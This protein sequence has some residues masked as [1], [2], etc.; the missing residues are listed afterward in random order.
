MEEKF[1]IEVD[2]DKKILRFKV[3][4]YWSE[5]DAQLYR[6]EFIEKS[7]LLM[8]DKWFALADITEYG[9]QNKEVQA[10]TGDLMKYASENG[11]VKAASVISRLLNKIQIEKLAEKSG[12]PLHSFFSSED[13]AEQW[14]LE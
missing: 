3:W 10:V 5:E 12:L 1:K 6:E 9:I 11:M 8:N 4:G 2:L 7:K 14:L 13:E